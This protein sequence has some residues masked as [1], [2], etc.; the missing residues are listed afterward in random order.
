VIALAAATVEGRTYM[1]RVI[2]PADS[3]RRMIQ[4]AALLMRER[5]VE[6]TSFSE[7][8]AR[9]GAPRGSIYHH[10]PGG[11]AQLIEESTRYAG[12][13]IAAGLVASLQSGDPGAA[14]RAFG[15]SW[16]AILSESDY[17]AGC[18]VV[19]ATLEARSH[20]GRA[21]RGGRCLR[22]LGGA[23][24]RRARP[25]GDRAREGRLDRDA[26]D[27]RHRGGGDRRPGAALERSAGAS[28]GR[29]GA[30]GDGRNCI[31]LNGDE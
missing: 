29:A 17:A 1:M 28:G 6:A 23:D 2:V 30:R 15:G 12:E 13:F 8:L 27:R 11:K 10:F 31:R 22:S 3:R 21:R 9:S 25:A 18:S 24:R 14:V 19:A 26:H 4:S 5:G 7:V 20:S 16:R